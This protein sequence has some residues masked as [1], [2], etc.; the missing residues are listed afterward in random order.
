MNFFAQHKD[1]VNNKKHFEFLMN[2][3]LI[4]NNN[5]RV[6][7]QYF[8]DYQRHGNW[9]ITFN[10]N[11]DNRLTFWIEQFA[12]HHNASDSVVYGKP[13]EEIPFS[14]WCRE[15]AGETETAKV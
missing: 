3:C 15:F 7:K 2:L 4:T 14:Y 6:T 8:D 1:S 11:F 12:I 10:A 13:D 5:E 9:K